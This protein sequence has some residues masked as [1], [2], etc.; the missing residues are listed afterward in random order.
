[1]GL[2]C[3]ENTIHPD[4]LEPVKKECIKIND[5]SIKNIGTLKDGKYSTFW[6]DK[7]I[8]PTTLIEYIVKDISHKD[9]P[10]GYPDNFV[11]MEW[12]TQVKNTSDDITF[13][14]DKDEGLCSRKSKYVFPLKSTIT[15]LTDIGGPTV[16]FSDENYNK[17]HLS[18]PKINKHV[19]F[20]GSSLHGV[21]GSLGEKKK[22]NK[23][24]VTL[25][26][27][28]WHYQPEKPNCIVF[29]KY[30]ILLSLTPEHMKVQE[31]NENIHSK[32]IIMNYKKGKDNYKFFRNNVPHIVTFAKNLK[33]EYTYSF[34]FKK[35]C[36]AF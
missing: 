5:Y 21:M 22:S 17:G 14:Y 8:E 16:I 11:G 12:W 15:Y 31:S 1:M 7:D 34:K 13:H 6:L 19:Q 24:R 33:R 4:L 35:D 10:N 3:Y 29:P 18:Y 26:I 28:Y 20:K 36:I 27:N 25:L 2:I 9:Y 30:D 23:K 32:V